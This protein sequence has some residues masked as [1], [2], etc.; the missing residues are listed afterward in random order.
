M[1]GAFTALQI[2]IISHYWGFYDYYD[3]YDYHDYHDYYDLMI[4]TVTALQI[5]NAKQYWEN[6]THTLRRMM[7]KLPLMKRDRMKDKKAKHWK[8]VGHHQ[9][10]D[11]AL[12]VSNWFL[13]CVSGQI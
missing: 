13:V 6:S 5:G 9:T 3:Y 10:L 4:G 7:N 12:C 8:S 2:C 11:L 1:F